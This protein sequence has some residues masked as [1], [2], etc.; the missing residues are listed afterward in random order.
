MVTSKIFVVITGV[1]YIVIAVFPK[2]G[3]AKVHQVMAIGM[4]LIQ[5]EGT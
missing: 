5:I 4:P 1:L 3:A 2:K